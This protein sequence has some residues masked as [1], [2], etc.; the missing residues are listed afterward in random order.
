MTLWLDDVIRQSK[1]PFHSEPGLAAQIVTA[2]RTQVESG[3]DQEHGHEKPG[4]GQTVHRRELAG[5]RETSLRQATSRRPAGDPRRRT[6]SA[7]ERHTVSFGYSSEG[8]IRPNVCVGLAR[9]PPQESAT[10]SEFRST[11]GSHPRDMPYCASRSD[12]SFRTS[13]SLR[14]IARRRPA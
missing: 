13:A 10:V 4:V 6:G 14:P 1:I 11:S 2:D 8:G 12:N 5:R 7:T 3:D 9:H